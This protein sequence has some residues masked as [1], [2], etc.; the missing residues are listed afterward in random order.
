MNVQRDHMLLVVVIP[1]KFVVSELLGRLKRQ[2][3][4]KLLNKFRE[5]K[6]KPYW[7]NHFRAKGY[8]VD[9]VVLDAEMIRRYVR[10]QEDNERQMEQV[11]LDV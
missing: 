4:M 10:Y 7:G 6:K 2:T 5:L 11:N 1:P 9:T 8:C 3:S